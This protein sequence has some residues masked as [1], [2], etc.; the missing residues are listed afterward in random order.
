MM[1]VQVRKT[2]RR[3]WAA[4]GVAMLADAIQLAIFPAVIEGAFSPVDDVFDLLVAGVLTLLVGWHIAFIPSF[5]VKLMP[6]ADLAPTWTVAIFIATWGSKPADDA[7]VAK[8][9]FNAPQP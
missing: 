8:A 6:V 1:N 2:S 5:I 7:V 3:I 4:R 9:Q